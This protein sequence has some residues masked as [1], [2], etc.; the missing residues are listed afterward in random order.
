MTIRIA[1]RLFEEIHAIL[2][3]NEAM[4]EPCQEAALYHNWM[5]SLMASSKDLQIRDLVVQECTISGSYF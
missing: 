4:D 2:R 1:A 5:R 3:P